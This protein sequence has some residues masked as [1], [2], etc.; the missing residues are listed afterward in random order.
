MRFCHVRPAPQRAVHTEQGAGR[1][2]Q[3]TQPLA[4]P[5]AW[6]ESWNSCCAPTRTVGAA[7]Q[8]CVPRRAPEPLQEPPIKSDMNNCY[9]RHGN[10]LLASP[11]SHAS[12]RSS[13]PLRVP[14]RRCG[15]AA[16]VLPGQQQ[17]R[18]T[19]DRAGSGRSCL[20]EDRLGPRAPSLSSPGP[21]RPARSARC[22]RT[23][24]S[25]CLSIRQCIE[26]MLGKRAGRHGGSRRRGVVADTHRVGAGPGRPDSRWGRCIDRFDPPLLCGHGAKRCRARARR[27]TRGTGQVGAAER[28]AAAVAETVAPKR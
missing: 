7:Q 27:N 24:S 11:D 28:C 5:S 2:C 15:G 6:V 4:K 22:R 3:S 21:Q 19:T 12:T 18:T 26:G 13:A 10:V 20:E 16:H 14:P 17:P 1:K 9:F 25:A 23:H 8:A